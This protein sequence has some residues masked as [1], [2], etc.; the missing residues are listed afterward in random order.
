MLDEGGRRRCT[1]ITTLHM[2][3]WGQNRQSQEVMTVFAASRQGWHVCK[4]S[5]LASA[6]Y[7]TLLKMKHHSEVG[8]ER[9][10]QHYDSAIINFTISPLLILVFW[11]SL[12]WSPISFV[13]SSVDNC[14]WCFVLTTKGYQH[15]PNLYWRSFVCSMRQYVAQAE[16]SSKRHVI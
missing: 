10:L 14:V 9:C 1:E 5:E 15:C 6:I 11:T 3:T 8:Q 12:C 2:P 4:R 13:I 16:M 7:H